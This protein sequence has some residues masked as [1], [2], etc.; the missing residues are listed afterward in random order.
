[1]A[2]ESPISAQVKAE[3]KTEIPSASAGRTLDALVDIIRPFTERRGLK[4]DL[5]RLQRE[6]VALKIARM[7]QERIEAASASTQPIPNKGLVQ[8]L[9]HASLEEAGDD[10]MVA[11]WAGLLA[12][13]AINGDPSLPRFVSILSQ[14]NGAQARLL[15]RMIWHDQPVSAAALAGRLDA[16]A[17]PVTALF[18]TQVIREW[19]DELGAKPLVHALH[20]HMLHPGVAYYGFHNIKEGQLTFSSELGAGFAALS[21]TSS[22]T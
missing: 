21:T 9:E 6:E 2:I 7:A 18:I 22:T 4:A 1:M 13:A 5:I 3:V 10:T 11:V 20:E 12:S 16:L 14:L 15:E 8:L 19:K 17:T